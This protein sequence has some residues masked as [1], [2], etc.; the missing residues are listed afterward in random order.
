MGAPRHRGM[1]GQLFPDEEEK[2]RRDILHKATNRVLYRVVTIRCIEYILSSLSHQIF[3]T[4]TKQNF[5]SLDPTSLAWKEITAYPLCQ[6][7]H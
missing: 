3:R 2:D 6:G 1:S 5:V 4:L 7:K